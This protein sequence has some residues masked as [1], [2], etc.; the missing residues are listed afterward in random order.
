MNINANYI[1]LLFIFINIH[2][3]FSQTQ[4]G[5]IIYGA[6]AGDNA[7]AIDIENIKFYL[8]NQS[9]V[10]DQCILNNGIIIVKGTC[11]IKY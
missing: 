7:G 2:P 4:I 1:I 6:N 5:D 11:E 8:G 3:L 10:T 9:Q